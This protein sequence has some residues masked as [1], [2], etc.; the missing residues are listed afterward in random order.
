MS[1][2]PISSSLFISLLLFFFVF[3]RNLWI[4]TS[5]SIA[6]P[7]WH[8][9]C[10]TRT[11]PSPLPV[12]SSPMSLCMVITA[13]M[14]AGSMLKYGAWEARVPAATTSCS[15]M[16]WSLSGSNQPRKSDLT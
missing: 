16:I 10:M 7:I 13:I 9:A 6:S 15:A 5:C 4:R 11:L 2:S 14:S 8:A 1:E 3:S 12:M